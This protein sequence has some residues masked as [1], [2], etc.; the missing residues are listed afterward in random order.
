MD[1]FIELYDQ[2]ALYKEKVEEDDSDFTTDLLRY[3]ISNDYYI[4]V[5]RATELLR[6]FYEAK[7]ANPTIRNAVAYRLNN[8]YSD[9]VKFCLLIDVLRCYD[10]LNHPTSFTKP[11]GIAL[12]IL[13]DKIIGNNEIVS[14]GQLGA[15][16]AATLS[17]IDLVPYIS[18]CSGQLGSRYSLFLPT[19]FE[20]KAPDLERLYRRLLYNLCKT[21]AEVDGD[22]TISE[23]EWLQEIALLNDDDPNNDIDIS[24]F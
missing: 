6:R 17:L 19:I 10:G 13:L 9:S 8:N 15:V 24:G 20:K 2:Y 1:K 21:I 4:K 16:S 12:M 18:E 3:D 7:L 5:N 14:Y 23:Q 22:I 11:E